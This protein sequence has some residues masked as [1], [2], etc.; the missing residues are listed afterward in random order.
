[1]T[2][3]AEKQPIPQKHIL[4]RQTTVDLARID[5]IDP[6]KIYLDSLPPGPFLTKEQEK[7]L[8]ARMTEGKS[9][10]KK[11]AAEGTALSPSIRTELERLRDA[12]RAARNELI[13]KN[14]R[15][16]V[17][18]AKKYQ[19][20]GLPFLDVIQEGNLGLFSASNKFDPQK[21]RFST[22]ATWWIRQ[23]IQRAIA[24]QGR[25]IRIPILVG[26]R[27]RKIQ[28]ISQRLTQELH[29][30]PTPEEIAAEIP[31]IKAEK[32]Q[33]YLDSSREI[34]SLEYPA[35]DDDRDGETEFGRYIPD[36]KQSPP[37]TATRDLLQEDLMKGVNSLL[38]RE[39][40]ILM[41]RFGLN[42]GGPGL[43][44]E[45]TGRKMNLS[46]ERIRQIEAQAFSRLKHPAIRRKLHDYLDNDG[47]R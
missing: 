23:T 22:Y 12:E 20:K 44:L 31:G 17:D 36:P 33:L 5:D 34:L 32:V 40:K 3:R 28:S 45:E 21:G 47:D 16:V 46:R 42:G 1:M 4:P 43:T 15:L 27:I 18:V 24:E 37:E 8:A 14:L 41:L 29:R 11:L 2:A 26:D 19:G 38:P 9:A 25:T 13:Q 10:R 7:E 35:S 6:V 30:D 39:A